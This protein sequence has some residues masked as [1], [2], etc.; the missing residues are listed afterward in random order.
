VIAAALALVGVGAVF[1]LR[2]LAEAMTKA[3]WPTTRATVLSSGVSTPAGRD[4]YDRYAID[5]AYE[6]EGSPFDALFYSDRARNFPAL[7]AKYG[8]GATFDVFYNPARPAHVEVR[9]PLGRMGVWS[10]G[11]AAY[12]FYFLAAVSVAVGWAVISGLGL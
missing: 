12:L 5:F 8:D 6:V 9:D 10:W 11:L 1:H 7:S 2:S 3:S 4:G